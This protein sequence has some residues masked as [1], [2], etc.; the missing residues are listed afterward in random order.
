MKNKYFWQ[1]EPVDYKFGMCLVRENKAKPMYW[2]NF[3]CSLT[4]PLGWALI[5]AIKITYNNESFCIANHFG[6]GAHK[7][8]NGGW[9]N[10][11]HFTLP[12]DT[13]EELP[14]HMG[15]IIRQF[16]E[17]GYAKHEAERRAWQKDQ[18]PEEFSKIERLKNLRN[19]FKPKF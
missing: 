5:P 17:E 16:D 18:Y 4:Y 13:F 3:E 9:P 12:V 7:L 1:G 10:Y 11:S 6:I 14:W 15:H 8:K 19:L 2:Y